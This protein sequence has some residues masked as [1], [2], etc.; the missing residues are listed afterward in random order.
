LKNLKTRL[1]RMPRPSR[2]PSTFSRAD[3]FAQN[4]L[5]G[6]KKFKELRVEV[7]DDE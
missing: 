2:P 3:S 1:K 5:S 6:L 7:M 4:G